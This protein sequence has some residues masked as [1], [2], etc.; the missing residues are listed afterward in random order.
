MMK[1]QIKVMILSESQQMT[2]EERINQD[3]VK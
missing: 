1:A 3:F 2:A